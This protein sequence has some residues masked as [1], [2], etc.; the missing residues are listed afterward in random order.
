[1]PESNRLPAATYANATMEHR[2]G[3]P[4]RVLFSLQLN[5]YTSKKIFGEKKKKAVEI[6]AGPE[7]ES[8]ELPAAMLPEF[9]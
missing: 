7:P 2:C 8:N 9:S 6:P 3:P 1:M 5:Q 4:L